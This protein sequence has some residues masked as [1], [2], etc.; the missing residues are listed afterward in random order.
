MDELKS[1]FRLIVSNRLSNARGIKGKISRSK[2]IKAGDTDL[3]AV[4]LNV[5]CIQYILYVLS[6]SR[7]LSGDSFARFR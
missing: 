5:Y 1:T 4:A 7:S 2:I 3:E 6:V